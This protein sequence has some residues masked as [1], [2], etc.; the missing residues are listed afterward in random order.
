[1]IDAA[2]GKVVKKAVKKIKEPKATCSKSQPRPPFITHEKD[3]VRASNVMGE[4]KRKRKEDNSQSS[5][6]NNKQKSNQKPKCKTC[7]KRHYGKCRYEP[8]SQ[9]QPRACGICKSSEHK[10]LE[11]QKIGEATCYNCN[12]KGH[13]KSNCPR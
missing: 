1:M 3:L 9:S 13:I 12:E 4:L 2:V 8:K 10:T 11:C 6:K 7:K 5:K